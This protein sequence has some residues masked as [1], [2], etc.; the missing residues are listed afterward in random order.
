MLDIV[1]ATVNGRRLWG[2]AALAGSIF[3]KAR[4][5]PG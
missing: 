2:K 1:R 3:N 4:I 5:N